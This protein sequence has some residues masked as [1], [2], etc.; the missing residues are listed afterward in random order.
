[1]ND[2]DLSRLRSLLNTAGRIARG[3]IRTQD[4]SGLDTTDQNLKIYRKSSDQIIL[5]LSDHQ[6]VEG[7]QRTAGEPGEPG[8]LYRNALLAE[9]KRRNLDT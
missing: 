8:E 4:G 9:I 1:M 3:E 2:S 7:Y 6:L 5:A